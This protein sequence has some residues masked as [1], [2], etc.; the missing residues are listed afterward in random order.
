MKEMQ[1]D[2]RRPKKSIECDTRTV[3]VDDVGDRGWGQRW[4]SWERG[5]EEVS[6]M[7]YTYRMAVRFC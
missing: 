3:R 4:E 5:E 2:E 6:E 7:S 1:E